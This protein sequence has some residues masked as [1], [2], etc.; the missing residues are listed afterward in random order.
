MI[1]ASVMSTSIRSIGYDSNSRMLEVEFT[2]QSVYD[3]SDVP[4]SVYQRFIAAPSKGRF[5]D[6]YIK[7]LYRTRRI[8]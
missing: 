1:R 4:A 3:Y 6:S 8:K 5:F 7:N 2:N